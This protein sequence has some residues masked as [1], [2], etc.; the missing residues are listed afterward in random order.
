[1][2]RVLIVDDESC[3]REIYAMVL[4][5]EGYA[6]ATAHDGPAA[7]AS[8]R[9][10]RP[11][12]VLLDVTMPGMSGYDVCRA[13]NL[14]ASAPSVHV[15]MMSAG[16]RCPRRD[17]AIAFF[18]PKPFDLDRLLAIVASLIGAPSEIATVPT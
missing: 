11:D 8:F 17:P 1:M 12:L 10:S 9:R 16:S 14:E 7:L 15:I 5:D 2:K 18:L 6:V 3:L 13:M 4:S